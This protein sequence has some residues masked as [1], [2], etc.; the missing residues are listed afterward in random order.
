MSKQLALPL[1]GMQYLM[2]FIALLIGLTIVG[3][4]KA[5]E[6]I[7]YI[8]PDTRPVAVGDP[9]Q[10]FRFDGAPPA[11]A[12]AHAVSRVTAPQGVALAPTA[13]VITTAALPAVKKLAMKKKGLA[14]CA[15]GEEVSI[16][17]KPYICDARQFSVAK[18]APPAKPA[19]CTKGRVIIIDD[20]PY[21]C[22]SR[23]F[24]PKGQQQAAAVPAAAKTP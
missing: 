12:T 23:G 18:T 2:A 5:A 11:P 16:D 14:E 8:G 7:Q 17:G 19:E 6:P 10:V 15:P 22:G 21:V 24:V 9:R 13:V 3:H 1:S 4:A 20:K